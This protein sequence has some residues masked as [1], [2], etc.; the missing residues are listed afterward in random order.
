MTV[1][2]S[3]MDRDAFVARFGGVYEQS[4]WLAWYVFD[5]GITR[6]DGSSLRLSQAMVDIC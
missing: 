6:F 1:V 4:P 2:S 5:T 3:Q